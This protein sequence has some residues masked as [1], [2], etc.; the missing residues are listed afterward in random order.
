MLNEYEGQRLIMFWTESR[1]ALWSTVT[2]GH[3]MENMKEC[4][5]GLFAEGYVLVSNFIFFL[6]NVKELRNV[7]QIVFS[8]SLRQQS[9]QQTKA[10]S[11]RACL[12]QRVLY[13][14]YKW[15]LGGGLGM[16]EYQWL[17]NVRTWHWFRISAPLLKSKVTPMMNLPP[18]DLQKNIILVQMIIVNRS[19]WMGRKMAF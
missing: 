17:F 12:W 14:P 9:S 10:S 18:R 6:N 11:I 1:S 7:K 4:W 3:A 2:S 15:A 16:W 13:S 19:Q 5:G 8:V